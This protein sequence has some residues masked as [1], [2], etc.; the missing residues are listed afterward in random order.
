M[1]CMSTARNE[2]CKSSYFVEVEARIDEFPLF[3]EI[4][5]NGEGKCH[6]L[7]VDFVKSCWES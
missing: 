3:R 2:E 6:A 4:N 1:Q 7:L 5:S